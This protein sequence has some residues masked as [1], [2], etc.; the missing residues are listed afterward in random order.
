[1]PR[2]RHSKRDAMSEII[3]IL[4]SEDERKFNAFRR[5]PKTEQRD[6]LRGMKMKKYKTRYDRILLCYAKV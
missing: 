4:S 2:G 6:Q 3:K 1:M 5:L